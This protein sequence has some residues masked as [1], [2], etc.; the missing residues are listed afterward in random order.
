MRSRRTGFLMGP[1][2]RQKRGGQGSLPG[3]QFGHRGLGGAMLHAGELRTLVRLTGRYSWL[4]SWIPQPAAAFPLWSPQLRATVENSDPERT[5]H[6]RPAPRGRGAG[7]E[8]P[9]GLR[10][11]PGQKL[12]LLTPSPPSLVALYLAHHVSYP[13]C[14]EKRR[15]R[16]RGSRGIGRSNVSQGQSWRCTQMPLGAWS[17]CGG[18]G[19]QPTRAHRLREAAQVR[20][21]WAWC[22]PQ[23]IYGLGSCCPAGWP[24]R[25]GAKPG[26]DPA[27]KCDSAVLLLKLPGVWP[28]TRAA[29]AL[30]R[31]SQCQQWLYKVSREDTRGGK[32]FHMGGEGEAGIPGEIATAGKTSPLWGRADP[33]GTQRIT[34]RVR[35][36]SL[37][38][39]ASKVS[40]EVENDYS[41]AIKMGK[42]SHRTGQGF[43]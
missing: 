14:K 11:E 15:Q 31:E 39:S 5:A 18:G 41:I 16:P 7:S 21:G 38:L 3:L 6:S 25:R 19:V 26:Q 2:G 4:G 10:P 30:S 40:N 34:H 24:G 17:H 1:V 32:E 33:R 35:N 29:G 42:L 13:F 43:V 22:C 20:R 27:G 36:F 23:V 28:V 9:R 37:I 12:E 8:S